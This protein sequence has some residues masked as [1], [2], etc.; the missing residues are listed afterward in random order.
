MIPKE[1]LY[2]LLTEF[3][4][5]NYDEIT[6]C[7][8]FTIIYNTKVDYGTLSSDEYKLFGQLATLTS[9]FAPFE[10][11]VELPNVYYDEQDVK[12]KV[13]EIIKCLL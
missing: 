10:E 3:Q 6:F 8:Q 13:D 7:D 9:R 1:E 12:L 2:Y 5:G 11:R 4:K